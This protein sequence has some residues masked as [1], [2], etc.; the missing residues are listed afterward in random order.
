[1][2]V[3][4]MSGVSRLTVRG[5]IAGS[6][7]ATMSTLSSIAE[8]FDRRLEL[9]LVPHEV[10]SELSTVAIGMKVLADGD[11]SW[12]I[13]FMELVD[14]FRHT[15]DPRLILLPPPRKLSRPLT[16]LLSSIVHTLAMEADMDIPTWARQRMYL[17][18]PWFVSE[19]EA[20]KAMAIMESPLA[21]RQ[22]NIFVLN[23][24]LER[25]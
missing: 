20:L 9:L 25:A 12:K 19:S 14:E 24:F 15:L 21:F 2:S 23:N 22:N 13:H 8:S 6:K 4:K 5:V 11:P 18:P 7:N 1:M 3:A 17:H 16:A 10:N